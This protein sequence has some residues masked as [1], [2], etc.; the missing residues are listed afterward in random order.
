MADEN[1]DSALGIG[2]APPEDASQG[3]FDPTGK[4]VLRY[5]DG[6]RVARFTTAMGTAVKILGVVLGVIIAALGLLGS[7][8][9]F[10]SS[11][12]ETI[13]AVLSL[14]SGVVVFGVFFILGVAVS[15]LGQQLK[16]ALDSAVNTSPFLDIPAKA[17]VMSL[18]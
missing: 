5:R 4:A 16:A 1:L 18:E 12:P 6:Y 15:A 2:A 11:E 10:S 14:L 17:K 13:F 9:M 7:Q 8:A 3:S